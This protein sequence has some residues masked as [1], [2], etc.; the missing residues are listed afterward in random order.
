MGRLDRNPLRV[1]DCKVEQC[2]RIIAEAPVLFDYLCP[3]CRSHFDRFQ[4][5]LGKLRVPFIVNKRLVRGLD[6]YT[7]TVFEATSQDLAARRRSRRAAGTTTSLRRWAARP[8]PA[9]GFAIGMERLAL[10]AGKQPEKKM[11]LYFLAAVGDDAR[12]RVI[13]LLDAFVLA[14]MQ[15]AYA[16]PAGSLKSQM[17][18]ANSLGA[19]YVLILAG[20]SWH[21]A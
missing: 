20:M 3:D 21:A 2:G 6:Y 10:I 18:H 4:D 12:Y 14:G 1:F 7:R 8:C 15:L 16:E 13:P 9:C 19:D 5:H 17:K 11:P